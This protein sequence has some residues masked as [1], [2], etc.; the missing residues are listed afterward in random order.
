MEVTGLKQRVVPSAGREALAA[1]WAAP[2]SQDLT[3]SGYTS[4]LWKPAL[5][6]PA[7][8][9]QRSALLCHIRHPLTTTQTAER[10]VPLT[11]AVNGVFFPTNTHVR[12]PARLHVGPFTFR[13]LSRSFV[14]SERP[15]AA[16]PWPGEQTPHAREVLAEG[17]FGPWG[18][19]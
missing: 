6:T 10:S 3:P 17:G 14:G 2:F 8:L 16:G 18:G 5:P 12:P 7:S 4:P 13:V 19:C 15:G 1:L 9:P 11:H